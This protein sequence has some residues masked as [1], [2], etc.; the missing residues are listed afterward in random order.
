M[1]LLMWDLLEM[2]HL[3]LPHISIMDDEHM[4]HLNVK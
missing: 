3:R 2:I 1:V 4:L